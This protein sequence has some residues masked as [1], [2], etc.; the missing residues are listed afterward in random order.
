MQAHT[1]FLIQ[2]R[3]HGIIFY[4]ECTFIFRCLFVKKKKISIIF[5]KGIN[6]AFISTDGESQSC[7]VSRGFLHFPKLIEVIIYER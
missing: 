1:S 5:H 7:R 2:I 4:G 3:I 6:V